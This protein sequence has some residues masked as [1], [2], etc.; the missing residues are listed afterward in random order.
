MKMGRKARRRMHFLFI[1]D[2]F[3]KG[4]LNLQMRCVK[5]KAEEGTALKRA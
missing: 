3:Q 2:S 5:S 1:V 4:G